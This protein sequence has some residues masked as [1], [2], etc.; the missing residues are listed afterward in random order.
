M[1]GQPFQLEG[2]LV[3]IEVHV[4]SEFGDN[5]FLNAPS[6][7]AGREL[8]DD[9]AQELPLWCHR[10]HGVLGALGCRFA[11]QLDTMG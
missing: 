5:M 1:R 3:A 2:C 9:A 8:K 6:F 11:P 7:G 4:P 10:I